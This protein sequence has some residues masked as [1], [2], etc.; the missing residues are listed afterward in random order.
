MAE[1]KKEKSDSSSDMRKEDV[2]EVFTR[3]LKKLK[4]R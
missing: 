4:T 2:K 3:V 1:E